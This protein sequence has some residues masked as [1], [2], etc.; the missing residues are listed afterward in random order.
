[1]AI[2]ALIEKKNKTGR[3][4]KYKKEYCTLLYNHMKAGLS[5][6]SFAGT[7]G[8][9][10]DTLYEWRKTRR[11]FS[12]AFK[13]GR[14]ASLLFWE[15]LGI[16]GA[17]GKIKNFNVAAYIYNMK[18]RFQLYG[19]PTDPDA[20]AHPLEGALGRALEQLDAEKKAKKKVETK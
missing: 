8:V 10:R 6:E 2:Q 16:H 7:I 20:K 14:E 12:D 15:R 17:A 1:M 19:Q 13:K 4:S 18:V 3:P 5:F 11:E 9:D